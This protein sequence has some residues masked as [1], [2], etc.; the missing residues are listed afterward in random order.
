MGRINNKEIAC[1]IYVKVEKKTLTK[2]ILYRKPLIDL[3]KNIVR[4]ALNR[5]N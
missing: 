3:L 1:S 4:K 5:D 2:K